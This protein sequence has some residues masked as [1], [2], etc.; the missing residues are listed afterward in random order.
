MASALGAFAAAV[1]WG[2]SPRKKAIDLRQ[3][4]FAV[5]RITWLEAAATLVAPA[6]KACAASLWRQSAAGECQV[7]STYGPG[8]LGARFAGRMPLRVVLRGPEQA[9]QAGVAALWDRLRAAG[10]TVS[11]DQGEEK[12]SAALQ[13][14]A[15][16]V[17]VLKGAPA[18]SRRRVMH[19]ASPVAA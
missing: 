13:P 12:M 11:D 5:R 6:D 8:L 7:S 18:R 3:V 1:L 15:A 16:V 4:A 17:R 9:P 14:A 19:E 10:F 2:M